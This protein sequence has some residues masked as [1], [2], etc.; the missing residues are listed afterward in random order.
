[1]ELQQLKYFKT[2]AE[3]GKISAAAE[4]LFLSPPALSTSISRLEKELGMPLFDRTG[5]RI[6]LNEQGEILL[7]HATRILDELEETKAELQQSRQQEQHI[8]MATVSSAQWVDLIS[9]FSQEYPGLPI[10]CTSLKF[11]H[12]AEGGLPSQYT[13]LF[14]SEDA[15]PEIYAEQMHKLPLFRDYPVI[16]VHD[17]HPLARRESVDIRELAEETLFLPMAGY[18][19]HA[20]LAELFESCGL[21]FPTGNAY[22]HLVSQQMA[23][24][25]RGIAFASTHTA[26][27]P[28]AK[29][30]YVPISTYCKPW[31]ASL[32]WKKGRKLNRSEQIF[33]AFVES[34]YAK[35]RAQLSIK[36]ELI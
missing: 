5:N 23:S 27:I 11:S 24:E 29:L 26:R 18:S 33:K 28:A 6:T 9:A 21:P 34:Y 7:R 15:V 19:L 22:P 25:Q 31:T 30:R 8:S 4:A 13:F 12:L 10:S 17:D 2:V 14:A 32:Y 3:T 16:V 20:H 1:M 35:D 36:S